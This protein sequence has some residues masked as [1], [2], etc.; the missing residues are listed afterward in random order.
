LPARSERLSAQLAASQLRRKLR[1]QQQ[2]A[3]VPASPPAS[4]GA[5]VLRLDLHQQQPHA[6]D[7]LALAA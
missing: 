1:R 3:V 5:V 7:R 6:L 2:G 4:A